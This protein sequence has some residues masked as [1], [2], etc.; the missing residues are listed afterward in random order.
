MEIVKQINRVPDI[1]W[2]GLGSLLLVFVG[3][4]FNVPLAAWI[5]PVFLLRYIRRAEHPL[6]LVPALVFM[7]A[8]LGVSMYGLVP[9][10]PA[11]QIGIGFAWALMFITPYL[12]DRLFYRRVGPKAG[13]FIFPSAYVLLEFILSVSPFSSLPSLAYT[14]FRFQ[15]LIQLV[16]VTGIWGVTFLIA[17]FASL[18]NLLWEENFRLKALKRGALLFGIIMAI[19]IAAGS[20]RVAL[21]RP[22]TTVPVG[23]V[24]VAHDNGRSVWKQFEGYIE[25]GT[26]GD[27]VPEMTAMA[28]RVLDRLFEESRNLAR[29]GARIILWSEYNVFVYRDD[30]EALTLRAGNFARENNVYLIMGVIVLTPGSDMVENSA[31]ALT[32]YGRTAF[33]YRKSHPVFREFGGERALKGEG[34]VPFMDTPYGRVATVIC[35]DMDFPRL[36]RQA[37]RGGADMLLVPALDWKEISPW[38]TYLALYR[39]IENGCSVV[40]Q[41]DEGMS[42]AADYRGTVLA[43]MDFFTAENRVM[44]SHVP[45][46]GT[47]TLYPWVGDWLVYGIALAWAA[48]IVARALS[49]LTKNKI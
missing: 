23:S 32:P 15:G 21:V 6:H 11:A 47:G 39:G 13:M 1:A 9:V 12:A 14:Q 36:V 34:I 22:G 24:T 48:C 44:I 42:L 20:L 16:S 46:K 19:T 31:V 25:N 33:T 35:Y 38:H 8:A 41:T 45:V 17:W 18:V 28:G 7:A 30:Y 2:L 49:R 26:P 10:P 3:Y 37:G 43:G 40:R 4:R 27:R 29:A 5:A